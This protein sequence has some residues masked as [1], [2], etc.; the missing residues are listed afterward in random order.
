MTPQTDNLPLRDIHLPEPV[1]W[2]PPAPGWWLLP[3]LLI[4]IAG[5]AWWLHRRHRRGALHRGAQQALQEIAGDYRQSPDDEQ[6]VQRLS[7]LLRRLSLSRYP[8]QQVAGLTGTAWLA[9]LDRVL[10]G[11]D[12]RE[13]VGRTLIHAPYTR[14]VKVDSEALLQLCERWVAEFATREGRHP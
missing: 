13:G 6:L 12:F 9:W 7:V 10:G 8:R 3:A 11:S 4:M 5:L 2:W 14:Q 1:A